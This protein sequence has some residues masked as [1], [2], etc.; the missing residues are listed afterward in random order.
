MGITDPT[1]LTFIIL[2][3]LVIGWYL[4]KWADSGPLAFKHPLHKA[5]A[6]GATIP[7]KRLLQKKYINVNDRFF[8]FQWSALH[9]AAMENRVKV[10]QLL[11]DH[12]AHIN[13]R[14]KAGYTAMHSAVNEGSVEALKCLV[15]NG[16]NISA[17][18]DLGVTPL[19]LAS[20][21]EEKEAF[22][23]LNSLPQPSEPDH[24]QNDFDSAT[25]GL[26]WAVIHG[27]YSALKI[28]LSRSSTEIN[29]QDEEGKTPLHLAVHANQRRKALLL[30]RSGANP[31][32]ADKYGFLPLH[33]AMRENYHLLYKS[34]KRYG[35]PED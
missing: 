7:I 9:I 26:H 20:I 32:I 28:A 8:K 16:A 3:S 30:L 29:K 22:D 6:S 4:S 17:L 10:I 23:Y 5:A 1:I 25:R 21:L 24:E 14:D 35:Y 12:G 18:N 34:L 11:I 33:Y 2:V 15:R 31:H 27:N 13:G 19:Q